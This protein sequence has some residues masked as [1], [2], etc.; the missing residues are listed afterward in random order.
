MYHIIVN[1][2]S[3]TGKGKKYWESLLPTLKETNTK[4]DVHFTKREGHAIELVKTIVSSNENPIY[5]IVLGGDGT[6]N[7]VIQGISDFE[8]TYIGYVPTGSSNDFARALQM[9]KSPIKNLE[10]ILS[11][12]KP[13]SYDI[14][15]LTLLDAKERLSG[16]PLTE[17]DKIKRLFC[18]SSDIGFGAAVCEEAL[19]SKIKKILNKLGLGKLTYAGIALRQI[20]HAPK[21]SLKVTI[22]NEKI[23]EV[24]SLFLIGAFVHPFEGGGMMFAPD[25]NPTD[26]LFDVCLAKD[27]TTLKT[28]RILPT[29]FSGKH[30]RFPEI[31]IFRCKTVE[32]ET[33]CYLWVHTDGEVSYKSKHVRLTSLPNTLKLLW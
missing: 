14:G 17:T 25:A 16:K 31:E 21:S 12:K 24:P 6:L 11:I 10:H 1:P 32:F 18:V 3:K 5:F 30:I 28:L 29:I 26:G 2:L 33:S 19:D 15:E 27:L 7:E 20:I 13:S 9:H 22:D 23:I 4:F 8:N